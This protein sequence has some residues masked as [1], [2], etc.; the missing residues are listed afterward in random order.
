MSDFEIIIVA[1]FQQNC[2]KNI[3]KNSSKSK[4]KINEG[5]TLGSFVCREGLWRI[6]WSKLPASSFWPSIRSMSVALRI[7]VVQAYAGLLRAQR[8][9]FGPGT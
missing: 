8:A 6:D 3:A 2:R 9:L 4:N 5:R 7:R 1:L